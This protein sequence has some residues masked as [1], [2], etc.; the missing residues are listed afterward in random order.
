MKIPRDKKSRI[1]KYIKSNKRVNLEN[2][3]KREICYK[4]YLLKGNNYKFY[5]KLKNNK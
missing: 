4:N 5:I 1:I 2:N 3:I